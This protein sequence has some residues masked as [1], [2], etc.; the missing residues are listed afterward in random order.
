MKESRR[1]LAFSLLVLVPPRRSRPKHR[2]ARSPFG[3][4]QRPLENLVRGGENAYSERFMLG[5]SL[6]R[7]TH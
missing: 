3:H 6:K 4:S 5:E 7:V 1:D 2:H